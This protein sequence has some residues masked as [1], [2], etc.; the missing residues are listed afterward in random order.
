MNLLLSS[1][2]PPDFSQVGLGQD[3]PKKYWVGGH[4]PP[5]PKF[6]SFGFKFWR[7]YEN[8]GLSSADQKWH[9]ALLERLKEL[10]GKPIED[11]SSGNCPSIRYH[12]ISWNQ[13]N[14]PIKK[15]HFA[16]K[17]WLGENFFENGNELYQFH[18]SKGYGRVIGFFDESMVFQV[19][20]LDKDHNAQPCK[21]KKYKIIANSNVEAEYA[22]LLRRACGIAANCDREKC[23]FSDRWK[24][25][26]E[27]TLPKFG[28]DTTIVVGLSE[29]VYSRILQLCSDEENLTIEDILDLGITSIDN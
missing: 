7:Q 8:F 25:L 26:R 21:R 5:S 9:V 23:V 6:F 12:P 2:L 4:A 3:A 27:Q 1:E 19:V 20:L 16:R 24:N 15:E 13:K 22:T 29:K 11:V 28:N 17:D 18:V 10:G 14:I